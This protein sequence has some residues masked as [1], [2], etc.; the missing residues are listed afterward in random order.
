VR[1]LDRAD[2][3]RGHEKSRLDVGQEALGPEFEVDE[4]ALDVIE[5]I[6]AAAKFRHQL[7]QFER[8]FYVAG[9]RAAFVL[10]NFLKFVFPLSGNPED[11]IEGLLCHGPTI[12]NPI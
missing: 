11:Q 12:Q 1:E 2:A 4:D 5:V 3:F 7:G 10:T 6:I 9:H 8:V